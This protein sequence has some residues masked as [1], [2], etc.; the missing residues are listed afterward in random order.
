[1][2]SSLSGLVGFCGSR[3]LPPGAASLVAPLVA[4]VLASGSGV[5][6]GCAS[7]ADGVVVSAALF[8]PGRVRVFCAFGPGGVGACGSVSSVAG[9]AAA[10]AAGASVL[11]LAGGPLSVPPPARLAR[12]SL[13]LVRAVAAEG[14]PLVALV[15]SL[16]SSSFG[17][18]PF[19]SCGSGSWSSVAAA[20]L[21][22]CPVVVVPCGGLSASSFP[23]LP[24][25]PC[26]G[27]WAPSSA[28][29]GAFVWAPVGLFC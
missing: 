9:V 22:R 25:A 10:A 16:P 20:A 23:S 14:G 21:L 17:P 12:R 8:A 5:A 19:P 1:V 24:G 15:A 11:W 13:A 3:A 27:A 6:V 29:P 7:G 18:G 4:A 26:G 2:S 28:W